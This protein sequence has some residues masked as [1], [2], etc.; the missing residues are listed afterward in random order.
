MA[1]KH[2]KQV[3][4]APSCDSCNNISTGIGDTIAANK[5][6]NGC[7]WWIPVGPVQATGEDQG[8]ASSPTS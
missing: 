3:E 6:S 7:L 4:R 8:T 2:S 5:E 1:A